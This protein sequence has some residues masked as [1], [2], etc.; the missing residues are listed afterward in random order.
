MTARRPVQTLSANAHPSQPR[1]EDDNLSIISGLSSLENDP[2]AIT[3][4]FDRMMLKNARD[5]RRLQDALRGRVQPFKKA[6]THPQVGLTLENLERHTSH[7]QGLKNV[8][9]SGSSAASD[10]AI[11]PPVEWGRKAKVKRNWLRTIAADV[12]QGAGAQE[13]A[14]KFA[15]ERDIPEGQAEFGEHAGAGYIP[16]RSIEDS[17]LSHKSYQQETPVLSRHQHS[18]CQEDHDLDLSLDFNEA[19]M[20]A[21]TPYIPRNHALDEIRQREI[22]SQREQAAQHRRQEEVHPDSSK[23]EAPVAED[24]EPAPPQGGSGSPEVRRRRSP[25]LFYRKSSETVGLVDPRVSANAQTPPVRTT[26][27]EDSHNLL[28]R[29]AR[30]S[31]TT[32]SPRPQGASTQEKH[33][34]S[35]KPPEPMQRDVTFGQRAPEPFQRNGVPAQQSPVLQPTTGELPIMENGGLSQRPSTADSARAEPVPATLQVSPQESKIPTMDATPMPAR[36]FTLT[37]KT[38]VVTGAWIDTPGPS[39]VARPSGPQ[40]ERSPTKKPLHKGKEPRARTDETHAPARR[41]VSQPA[42]PSSALQAI[43]EEAKS[44]ANGTKADGKEEIGDTTID[45]LEE[46]IASD[47]EGGGADADEDTLQG[48]QLPTEP[49]KTDSERQRRKELEQLHKMNQRLRAAR[50]SIRDASRGMRRVEHQVEHIEEEGERLGTILRNCPCVANGHEYSPWSMAW[51]GFR[52]LF[53]V[54]GSAKRHGLT[55][56]SIAVIAFWIWFISESITCEKYCHKLYA[57]SMVGYGVDW[58]APRFP[59]VIPTL[60]WRKWLR[61]V[62]SVLAWLWSSS[63]WSFFEDDTS[64]KAATATVR[65]VVTTVFQDAQETFDVDFSMGDDEII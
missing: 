50:T 9:P 7:G 40:T 48:L 36:P 21:S 26:R 1:P 11:R 25:A 45:F 32:P 19:S 60:L 15:A 12:D 55:W 46:L 63:D 57:T 51:T 41:R 6:R 62:W 16:R 44:K 27:R 33:A 23:K 18:S 37:A 17:P 5:E 65:R 54:P 8:S 22:E 31:S 34:S 20:I 64:R 52:R 38:P 29:L 2:D 13:D 10:P 35:E 56:L 30:A 58:D 53:Y 4:D 3:D 43:V 39:T 24:D 42:L 61:P 59:F 14:F 49:P 28:R 47:A